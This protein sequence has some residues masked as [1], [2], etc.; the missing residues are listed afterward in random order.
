MRA[1]MNRLE[2]LLAS[3]QFGERWGRHWLDVA[4]YA[5]TKGYVFQED[6]NYPKAYTYR[7]W[8]IQA[9]NDDLPYDR[10]VMAQLAAD[11]LGDPSAASRRW[12]S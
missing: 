11:Q 1:P 3:T 8:V 10:F 12:D 6:R 2:K 4:R 9:F 7:D 5:D